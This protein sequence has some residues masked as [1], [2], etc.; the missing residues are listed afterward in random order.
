ML[1]AVLHFFL[2]LLVFLL[3]TLES[4]L[5]VSFNSWNS[6]SAAGWVLS[7]SYLSQA[8]S[9]LPALYL[10]RSFVL[11]CFPTAAWGFV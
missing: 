1:A 6:V 9:L 4:F 10:D 8:I 2:F 3:Q 11:A 7:G 5:T